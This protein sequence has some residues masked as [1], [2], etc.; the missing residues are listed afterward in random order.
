MYKLPT[1]KEIDE[2]K[3]YSGKYIVVVYPHQGQEYIFRGNTYQKLIY[4]KF[5]DAGADVVI[6]SHPHVIENVEIYKGKYIFYS[7]GNFIFDQ[8]W[9]KTREHMVLDTEIN[10]LNFDPATSTKPKFEIKFT[11]IAAV[12]NFTSNDWEE[13]TEENFKVIFKNSPLKRNKF[14]GIKRNL[15]FIAST[16]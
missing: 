16:S 6:G 1:Q 2:I 10:I 4:K 13:L 8:S 14:A 7:L 11:P 12:L 15:T 3:K 9:S 5:I